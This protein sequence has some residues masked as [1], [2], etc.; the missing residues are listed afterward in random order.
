VI[1]NNLI[2]F[3]SNESKSVVATHKIMIFLRTQE[4]RMKIYNTDEFHP[5]G[6][7]TKIATGDGYM[8]GMV[9]K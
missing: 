9:Y 8:V 4:I 6:G 2:L 3:C 5:E 7:G 1:V